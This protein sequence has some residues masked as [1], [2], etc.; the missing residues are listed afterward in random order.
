MLRL[1]ET[2][3]LRR[4]PRKEHRF[5]SLHYIYEFCFRFMIHSHPHPPRFAFFFKRK[6]IA[7]HAVPHMWLE[8]NDGVAGQFGFPAAER[9]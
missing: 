9:G 6:S 7:I 2:L 1:E 8:S 5:F 4:T 3:L